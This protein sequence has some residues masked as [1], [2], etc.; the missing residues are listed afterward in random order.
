MIDIA[1][2]LR[3]VSAYGEASGLAE[4]TISG[5]LFDDGKRIG[6][7]RDGRDVGIRKV[8]AAVI[9][10]SEN[11]PADHPWPADIPRPTHFVESAS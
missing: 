4:S 5:R 1:Q 6:M 9:W 10:L 3:L 7:L 8:Q 2:F 11:W